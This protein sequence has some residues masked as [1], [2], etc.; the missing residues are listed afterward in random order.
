VAA[1]AHEQALQKAFAAG[2]DVHEATARVL[3]DR[4]PSVRRRAAVLSDTC[5]AI[6]RVAA[7]CMGKAVQHWKD[8][9]LGGDL[10]PLMAQGLHGC[11]VLALSV[12]FS[13]CQ[14]GVHCLDEMVSSCVSA[15]GAG[16]LQVPVDKQERQMGKR[17]NFSVVYGAG[18]SKI[19]KDA[20]LSPKEA[21][22][23]LKRCAHQQHHRQAAVLAD[24]W[25][26]LSWSSSAYQHA[27]SKPD[28]HALA[29]CIYT[30]GKQEQPP[31]RRNAMHKLS[32]CPSCASGS[33]NTHHILWSG[34]VTCLS[35]LAGSTPP[36]H[37]C[38]ST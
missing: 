12:C 20:G 34:H 9:L 13:A 5:V 3:L 19:G 15:I 30:H 25:A 2:R 37:P 6:A 31:A 11:S 27:L 38:L 23:F 17:V 24:P 35:V 4:H 36:T 10:V 22:E 32:S 1:L 28:E 16:G 26:C 33:T 29:P 14:Q 18:S 7:C 21:Q 8:W